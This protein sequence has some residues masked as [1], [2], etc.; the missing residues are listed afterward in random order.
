M[1]VQIAALGCAARPLDR[2]SPR[3]DE[4]LGPWSWRRCGGERGHM[5]T[6]K[7]A[8]TQFL[9]GKRVAV[10][11]VSRHPKVHAANGV[12]RRLRDRGY[13]V[14]AVNPNADEVEGVACY[15]DL[16]SIPG[17]VDWVL[18]GTSPEH[19]EDTV[20][21]C[22]DLG[23]RQVWMHRGPG[24]GS[25]SGRAAADAREHGITVIEGGCPC[26]FAPTADTGHKVMKAVFTLTGN[27]PRHVR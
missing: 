21:E 25:V 12:Y 16:K 22:A 1:C 13:E 26:M 8:A 14:V 10:T 3:V 18:V 24:H 17:G 15:H 23:I 20:R 19:A 27:V 7:Q 6:M 9:G 11:G 2:D 5:Q 4:V